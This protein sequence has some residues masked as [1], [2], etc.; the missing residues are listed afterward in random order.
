MTP[1]NDTQRDAVPPAGAV[2]DRRTD[3]NPTR[4]ASKAEGGS[5]GGTTAASPSGTPEDDRI[6]EMLRRLVKR[7]QP[8]PNSLEPG[9]AYQGEHTPAAPYRA[10]RVEPKTV[11]GSAP[12]SASGGRDH[13]TQVSRSKRARRWRALAIVLGALVTAGALVLVW[14]RAHPVSAP[15]AH[16]P[17]AK[18]MGL[19]SIAPTS[20]VPAAPLAEPRSTGMLVAPL[21]E[22][23]SPEQTTRPQA[24]SART[25]AA[26][27]K[28]SAS[29]IGPPAA[30]PRAVPPAPSRPQPSGNGIE[31]QR[32]TPPRGLEDI[33]PQFSPQ[34]SDPE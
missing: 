32:R 4:P 26:V 12:E 2:T 28:A 3:A 6:D 5:P 7:R 29:T 16:A 21:P 27:P 31:E 9:I 11:L 30:A 19:V 17:M 23:P 13:T 10:A 24:P 34:R 22:Q 33:N 20:N 1:P 14:T 8:V 25:P 18:A 15:T